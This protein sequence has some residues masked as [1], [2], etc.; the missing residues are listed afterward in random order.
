MRNE[1]WNYFSEVLEGTYKRAPTYCT[2]PYCFQGDMNWA[3]ASGQITAD[4]GSLETNAG[5]CLISN[6]DQ[7][8]LT[9]EPT[10]L[11]VSGSRNMIGVW[12]GL[13]RAAGSTADPDA[14]V[15]RITGDFNRVGV[16]QKLNYLACRLHL[17]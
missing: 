1:G 13:A 12:R 4:G 16:M 2:I 10:W 3:S 14:W 11:H 7:Y 9:M 8:S 5:S 17:A 15:A 6:L